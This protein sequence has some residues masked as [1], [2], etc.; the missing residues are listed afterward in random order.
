LH[1]ID[2]GK[3]YDIRVSDVSADGLPSAAVRA[4]LP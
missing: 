4:D 1:D 2:P 3:T